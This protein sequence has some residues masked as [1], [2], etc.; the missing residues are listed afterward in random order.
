MATSLK[1]KI[2][3]VTGGSS[4]IGQATALAAHRHGAKAVVIADLR[5][6]RSD[7]ALAAIQA[8][9]GQAT[10]VETDVSNSAQVQRLIA[11]VLETYGRIDCAV[12]N[13][14][15]EGVMAATADCTE[16]N[17]DQKKAIKNGRT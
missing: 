8:A 2:V 9:G 5:A 10:F 14:G 12:N 1:D 4:G 11:R 13:A 17:W 6:P 16:E 15:I 7:G 3:L